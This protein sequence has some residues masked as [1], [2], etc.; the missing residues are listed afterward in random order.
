MIPTD[1]NIFR[2]LNRTYNLLFIIMSG[3]NSGKAVIKFVIG[4]LDSFL[5]EHESIQWIL[6]WIVIFSG[7]LPNIYLS[8]NSEGPMKINIRL[9][10]VI[11]WHWKIP[12]FYTY[13]IKEGFLKINVYESSDKYSTP[14]NVRRKPFKFYKVAFIWNNINLIAC[15]G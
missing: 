15:V 4:F 13:I 8:Q 12:V 10:F 1:Y 3:K 2:Y 7:Q 11:D 5:D 6:C 9:L 14:E